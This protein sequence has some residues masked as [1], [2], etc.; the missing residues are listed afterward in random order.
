[1]RVANLITRILMISS[2][3]VETSTTQGQRWL[4]D[5]L[6]RLFDVGILDVVRERICDGVVRILLTVFAESIGDG[7]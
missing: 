6:E 4:V 3:A 5:S 1:M 2:V 7:L